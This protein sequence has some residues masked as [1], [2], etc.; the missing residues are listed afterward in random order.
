MR[1]S[2]SIILGV[3]TAALLMGSLFLS[4]N[5]M[6]QGSAPDE[7]V[8]KGCHNEG[9]PSFKGFDFA[10]AKAKIAHPNPQAAK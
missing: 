5:V 1:K 4:P 9:S 7:K 6:A 3:S 10:A 8:C 2:A